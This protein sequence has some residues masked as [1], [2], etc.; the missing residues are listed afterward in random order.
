M[1]PIAISVPPYH[2]W[3][4]PPEHGHLPSHGSDF[5]LF[6][7]AEVMGMKQLIFVKDEKGLYDK[8]PKKH[9]DATH[10]PYITLQALLDMK[11]EDTILDQ[12]L[13]QSWR[14]AR[15]VRRIQI[16]NGLERGQLL[17]ALRGEDVGT[18]IVKEKAK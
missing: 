5:G 8:D 4:P 3:E 11:L 10:I 13:F 1:I 15:N 14:T 18:V 7:I 16:V 17:A 2:L 12:Q 6:Q 9:A